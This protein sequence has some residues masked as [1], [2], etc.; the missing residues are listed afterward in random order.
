M[1]DPEPIYSIAGSDLVQ[2]QELI[3]DVLPTVL[4]DF[5]ANEQS[6]AYGIAAAFLY[7]LISPGPLAGILDY[8]IIGPLGKVFS[9]KFT[10]DDFEV[11]EQLGSGNFGRVFQCVLNQGGKPLTDDQ[12]RAN[13]VV[14]KQLKDDGIDLRRDFLRRGTLARGAGESGIAEMYVNEVL[15]RAAKDSCATY[16][17]SFIAES[18]GSRKSVFKEG[19]QF[20]IWKYESDATLEDFLVGNVPGKFPANAEEVLLGP[21]Q[22]N[23]S[24]EDKAVLVTKRLMQAIFQKMDRIH[25]TGIVHRDL[26]PS[27]L[28]VTATGKVKLIDFGAATDLRVGIN[29]NPTSGMLDPEYAPPE[30]LVRPPCLAP[31]G[32]PIHHLLR[33]GG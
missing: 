17:G 27:N 7:T 13:R 10:V 30:E 4:Q 33:L 14:V 28:L 32:A 29:F 8:Y 21:S 16:L 18:K 12:R 31:P 6:L 1:V 22:L 2:V 25:S 24:E 23:R 15:M 19:Q 3:S 26:K 5:Y 20:L 9:S 11:V